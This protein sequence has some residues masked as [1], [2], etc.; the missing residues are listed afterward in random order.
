MYSQNCSKWWSEYFLFFLAH[1]SWPDWQGLSEEP[2]FRPNGRGLAGNSPREHAT[3]FEPTTFLVQEFF[4]STRFPTRAIPVSNNSMGNWRC[5][6]LW[7]YI[8]HILSHIVP[9]VPS[10]PPLWI[11][12]NSSNMLC[13][14]VPYVIPHSS[15]VSLMLHPIDPHLIPYFVNGK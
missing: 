11:S 4:Y 6:Q 13:Q 9:I 7:V 10:C 14:N 12:S 2:T 8:I 5:F 3:G 15:H 1:I